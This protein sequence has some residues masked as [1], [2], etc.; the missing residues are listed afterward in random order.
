MNKIELYFEKLYLDICE[1]SREFK[2]LSSIIFPLPF[3]EN[4]DKENPK[5]HQK[6]QLEEI[7]KNI[8]IIG[9]RIVKVQRPKS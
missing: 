2:K 9:D 1:F 5:L 4:L 7:L 3:I 6:K 8:K